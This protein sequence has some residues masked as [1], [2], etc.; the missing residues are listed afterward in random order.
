MIEIRR[1]VAASGRDGLSRVISDEAV[2]RYWDVGGRTVA[3]V[4]ELPVP[5]DPADP[6]GD[7]D[8]APLDFV[9]EAGR[10]RVL[11][12]EF[13]PDAAVTGTPDER[14]EQAKAQIRNRDQ[15]FREDGLHATPTLDVFYVA[16]GAVELTLEGGERA[17]VC[18]GD[19]VVQCS[20]WHGW[21]NPHDEPCTIV[22]V[23][24]R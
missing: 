4:W 22:G 2:P 7:P 11:H 14:V 5:Y 6:G 24:F 8:P 20:T 10:C 17:S 3:V 12:V 21:R 18:A 1:V 15:Y 23:N 13:P 9:A 16:A 19:Y